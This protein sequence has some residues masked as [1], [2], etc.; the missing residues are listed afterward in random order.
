MV[1]VRAKMRAHAR[2]GISPS[3]KPYPYTLGPH[4]R[5]SAHSQ[6]WSFALDSNLTLTLTEVSSPTLMVYFTPLSMVWV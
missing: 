3:H 6:N 4:P 5:P 2:S 1:Y